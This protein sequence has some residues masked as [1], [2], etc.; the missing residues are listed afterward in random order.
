MDNKLIPY[1]V[2][3]ASKKEPTLGGI[4]K[5]SIYTLLLFISSLCLGYVAF[6]GLKSYFSRKTIVL[7]QP[8]ELI[9]PTIVLP[10]TVKRLSN[11][12][13]PKEAKYAP[14]NF[15]KVVTLSHEGYREKAYKDGP[16]YS[17]GPGITLTDDHCARL[18]ALNGKTICATKK[19]DT[20]VKPNEIMPL[21]EE[22]LSDYFNYYLGLHNQDTFMAVASAA[23]AYNRGQTSLKKL[24]LGGCCSSTFGCGSKNASIRLSHNS[25]RLEELAIA[26]R[27]KGAIEQIFRHHYQRLKAKNRLYL[28]DRTYDEYK[29][30]V[31]LR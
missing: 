4:I 5:N 29:S 18:K 21:F 14:L 20:K 27:K 31:L 13:W 7:E 1:T 6:K 9:P 30:A 8:I 17:I 15:L 16:V 26:T 23:Y 19:E 10:D 25:R 28:L 3:R 11:S 24:Q 22:M 2:A 12:Y